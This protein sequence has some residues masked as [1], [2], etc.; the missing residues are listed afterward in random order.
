M[1]TKPSSRK[2]AHASPLATKLA[3]C[4]VVL[5]MV[6]MGIQS[7]FLKVKAAQLTQRSLEISNSSVNATNVSYDF[8]FT[9]ATAGTLGS[10]VLELCTNDPFPLTPC[11]PPTGLSMSGATLSAQ[12]GQTGFSIDA[13]STANKIVLTRAPG[14]ASAISVN[15]VF[16]GIA[17][18]SIVSTYYGRLITY[19][20]NDTSGSVTDKAGIAWATTNAFSVSTEVPQFLEFC[21]GITI[22]GYSC[23][24][25]AGDNIDFGN[26]STGST[27][28]ATSQML[29]VTN[30][31]YGYNI[32]VYGL[33]MT[34]GTNT[35]PALAA[36]TFAAPGNSQFGMN[37]RVNSLPAIGSDVNGPGTA[38]VSPTYNIPDRYRFHDGDVVASSAGST[39][40]RKFTVTYITNISSGQPS[41]HYGTTI[42]YI[43]LANF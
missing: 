38:T 5:V 8:S 41:G 15:Y 34:S 40:Y 37:A 6:M 32:G 14:F 22:T 16:T 17:N 30:A 19:A 21:T 43:C 26:F 7:L 13:S 24:T 33:T 18:P 3:V 28:A 12:S 31:G 29:A 4:L 2:R 10:I 1:R 36:Q 9:L 39:D 25:A 20:S 42:T 11:V 27:A 35:I 23:L